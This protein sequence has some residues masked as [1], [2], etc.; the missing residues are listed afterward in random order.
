M[1]NMGKAW[2]YIE[3]SITHVSKTKGLSK[4]DK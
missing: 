4:A 3:G 2:E 1:P